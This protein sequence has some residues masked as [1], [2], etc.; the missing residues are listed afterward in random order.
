[1]AHTSKRAIQGVVI[2]MHIIQ[3]CKLKSTLQ[4]VTLFDIVNASLANLLNQIS[5]MERHAVRNKIKV[6]IPVAVKREPYTVTL[7]QDLLDKAR[8]E[9]KRTGVFFIEVLE[10]ALKET[11]K[12]DF[13]LIEISDPQDPQIRI[14][15]AAYLQYL[16]KCLKWLVFLFSKQI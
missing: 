12:Q 6:R 3:C 5:R 13:N 10:Y 1:M 7:S 16:H 8:A 4:G 2:Q 11:I 15:E 9:A 14:L